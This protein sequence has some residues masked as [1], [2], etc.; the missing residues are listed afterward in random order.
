MTSPPASAAAPEGRQTWRASRW[1]VAHRPSA[2]AGLPFAAIAWAVLASELIGLPEASRTAW[3]TSA[4]YLGVVMIGFVVASRRPV[5]TW[6]DPTIAALFCIHVLLVRDIGG[7]VLSGVSTLYLLPVLWLALTGTTLEVWACCALV[8]GCLVVPILVVGSPDYPPED[9]R[10]AFVIVTMGLGLGH[11]TQWTVRRLQRATRRAELA[12]MRAE[13]LFSDAPHGVALLDPNGVVVR[14]NRA[15]CVLLV[16]SPDELVGTR[17][18]AHEVSG[19]P[20]FSALLTDLESGTLDPA[21]AAG[22][23]DVQDPMDAEFAEV[24]CETALQTSSGRVLHVVMSARRLVDDVEGEH[25]LVTVVDISARRDY[26]ERLSELVNHDPITALPSRRR[27]EQVLAAHQH[28]CHLQ[29]PSGAL[30]LLDLDRFKQ[31]NDTLGHPIGDRVLRDVGELLASSVRPGDLV[32]RLGGD[33]FAVLLPEADEAAAL[34][35]AERIVARVQVR[36]ARLHGPLRRLGASIG[37][38]T[39]SAASEHGGDVLALADMTMYE[40]KERGRGRAVVL[41]A[42]QLRGPVLAERMNWQSRLERGLDE[43]TFELH[44]QPIMDSVTGAVH[45]AEVLVRLREGQELHGPQEFLAI[46]E[47]VGLMPRIDAWVIKHAVELLA[48]LQARAPEFRL[49]V[50][51]SALSLAHPGVESAIMHA[52]GRHPRVVRGLVLEVTETA[53]VADPAA[54][55]AFADRMAAV[56]CEFALDDFGTGFASLGTLKQIDFSYVKID[57]Q[58]VSAAPT[59]AVDRAILH[60]VVELARSLDKRTVAE[61]VST[62]EILSVVRDEGVD[63]VQGHLVGAPVPFDEFVNSFVPDMTSEGNP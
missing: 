37:V 33:E 58:F 36:A 23:A 8:A 46:A 2:W 62:P 25:I 1:E 47:G 21:L 19:Q 51:L 40:A 20:V 48:R 30:L 43:D 22:Q 31:V 34:E 27:F 15:M 56:G 24:S 57:G 11:A 63:Y 7:G 35:V 6:V 29:G 52:L 61:Y 60:S 54:A 32:A 18:E 42:G 55:R 17:L 49:G 26:E 44:L 53:A 41:G 39:F 9:W 5:R 28:R 4:L 13:R 38:V 10:R 12:S 45:S 3:I 14:A 59:S 16:S 50:N